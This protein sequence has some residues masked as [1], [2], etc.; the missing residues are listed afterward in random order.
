MD[1]S[2]VWN[3]IKNRQYEK[4]LISTKILDPNAQKAEILFLLGEI[5]IFRGDFQLAH[6]L[7][8]EGHA[9]GKQLNNNDLISH[10][11][12]AQAFLST[13]MGDLNIADEYLDQSHAVNELEIS[14]LILSYTHNIRS[15]NY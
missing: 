2:D 10:A 8:R 11:L 14:E 5:I 4:A 13:Q 1:S 3:F 6:D 7:L 15:Y 9:I 12:S